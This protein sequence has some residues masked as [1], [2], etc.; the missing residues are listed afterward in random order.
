MTP[1]LLTRT[2]SFIRPTDP[3]NLAPERLTVRATH[4]TVVLSEILQE[5]GYRHGGIND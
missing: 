3:G 4:I 5:K 2:N 1:P